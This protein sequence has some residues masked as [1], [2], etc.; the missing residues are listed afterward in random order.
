MSIERETFPRMLERPGRLY[1]MRSGGYWL[2]IGT[3]GKYFDAQLDVLVGRVGP[4][5][6]PTAA[7]ASPGCGCEPDAMVDGRAMLD[8]A[9]AGR[10]PGRRWPPKRT[11][12]RSV[13]GAD[14]LIGA[15]A[16]LRDV[17][18]LDGVTVAAGAGRR[19]WCSGSDGARL[20]IEGTA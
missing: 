18:V 1:A 14:A 17:V 13:V 2:D 15:G 20:E 9:G 7:E 8:G 6:T 11:L 12:D 19:V 16:R 10:G 4:P 5:P 3:P